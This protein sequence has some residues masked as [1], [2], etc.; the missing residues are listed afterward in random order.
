LGDPRIA[1][2]GGSDGPV[3]YLVAVRDWVE[4]L[5]GDTA[6]KDHDDVGADPF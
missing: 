3:I 2:L 6:F 1:I 4:E 5:E